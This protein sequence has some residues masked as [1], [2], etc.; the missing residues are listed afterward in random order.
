MILT[1]EEIG[2][3]FLKQNDVIEFK[4]E[5]NQLYSLADINNM[6]F[7][8]FFHT[9]LEDGNHF[10]SFIIASLIFFKDF[11]PDAIPLINMVKTYCI[12]LALKI[13]FILWVLNNYSDNGEILKII[14]L[15]YND[16]FEKFDQKCH[17]DNDI[18]KKVF[19]KFF[20]QND[21]LFNLILKLRKDFQNSDKFKEYI[22]LSNFEDNE[23]KYYKKAIK[24]YF[25][26]IKEI[27]F[28]LI[29]YDEICTY[30]EK[31]FLKFIQSNSPEG[32]CFDMKIIH[33]NIK[34]KHI[35]KIN[36]NNVKKYGFVSSTH[37]KISQKKGTIIRIKGEF[38]NDGFGKYSKNSNFC[39]KKIDK[40][41][42]L[43]LSLINEDYK[44]L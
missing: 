11:P 42:G 25:Y 26:I 15:P 2:K 9:S 43:N 28:E 12:P 33:A 24:A 5:F 44:Q 3:S 32:N 23:S 18:L 10:E 31:N 21:E 37:I 34:N 17:L 27:I 20:S 1:V 38:I 16:I 29:L 6:F 14:D 30:D 22:R 8:N 7:Y 36:Y 13:N 40:L 19:E 41:S 39:S 4:N 35:M